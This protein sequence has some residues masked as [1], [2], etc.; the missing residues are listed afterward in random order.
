MKFSLSW[1]RDFVDVDVPVE[2]IEP[3][4]TSLG[5]EVASIKKRHIPSGIKVAKILDVAKHPN[6]D[7]LHVCTVDAGEGSPLTIVCGAPN[8][9]AGM[10][11][12]LATIGTKFNDTFII[13]KA[14]LRG[15]ESFGMLCS[16][17]ELGLS[18]NHAGL[19]ALPNTMQIGSEVSTYFPDDCIIEVELTPN[20]GDCQSVLGIA[21]DV[22]A[23]LKKPL[24]NAALAPQES[25]DAKINEFISVAIEA[26]A[27]CPRYAGRLVRNVKIVSSPQWMA[28][29]LQ[30]A[31]VRPINNVVDITNYMML[32]YGQP[33]HAFDYA[34]I[35]GKQVVVRKSGASIEFTTLDQVKRSIVADD[36]VICDGNGPVALAGIMGGLGSEISNTT[37]DVFLECAYFN[38]GQIRKTAKRL[39]LSTESSYRFERGVDSTNA[40]IWALDTAAELLRQYAGGSI[41]RGAIDQYPS[42]LVKQEITLRPSRVTKLLGVPVAVADIQDTLTRLQIVNTIIG[43]DSL[44]CI[45]PAYRHDI[46]CEADLIEE[47]GRFYGYDNIPSAEYAKVSLNALPSI[48]E[49]RVDAIRHSL[50]FLGMSETV[51]NSLTSEKKNRLAAPKVNPVLLL[52]PLSPDMA[53]MRASMLSSCLENVARNLNRKNPDNNFFEIGRVF[54]AASASLLTQE[55]DILAIVLCGRFFTNAW[56]YAQSAKSDFYV[57]KGILEKLASDIGVQGFSY[58]QQTGNSGCF[59][60]AC[61]ISTAGLI[62]QMGKVRPDTCA[63]FDIKEPVFYAELDITDFVG[64]IPMMPLFSPLPKY[65][66]LER[67][68]CFVL[69]DTIAAAALA[70]EI[71]A[72]SS[73]VEDVTP[74]D[75]YRGEKLGIGLKSIAFSVRMRSKDRTLIDKEAEDICTQIIETMK[76]K[77]NAT[78]RT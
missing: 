65:P 3:I 32:S 26:P 6:A 59:D 1:L 56:N 10:I 50:A 41:V 19:L 69:A 31:G 72:L 53:Q 73:I 63:A 52:N 8:A 57:L 47:I 77:F 46:S 9:A 4:L 13:T 18:D 37:T 17:K 75:V 64:K 60:Q 49:N 21:R 22:A 40:L 33:M 51:S 62:G 36:L 12:P 5:L 68:F 42:P 7:K 48:T 11:A 24:K 30:D 71:A 38:P 15:V 28:Q 27:L 44:A 61:T 35:G 25:S 14:K 34:R 39:C 23:K 74:F 29:R 70:T 58:A 2:D 43:P 76:K 67:D 16:E 54:S 78:L 20:R 55:R 45:S 66:A